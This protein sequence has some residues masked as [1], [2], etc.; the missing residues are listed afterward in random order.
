MSDKPRSD[1]KPNTAEFESLPYITTNGFREYDARWLFEKE[2]NLLGVQA[3]GLCLGTYF[4]QLGIKPRV[5]TGHD[6]RAYQLSIKQALM[7][8]LMNAGCEVI[9]IGLATTPMCY[10]AQFAL[11]CP[12]LAMVTAS[13]N[14]NG[15]TGVKMGANPPLTFGPDEMTALKSMVLGGAGVARPG[16]SYKAV[17]DFRAQYLDELTK[18]HKLS[19]SIRVAVACGNGTAGLFGPEA[20]RR[21]GADVVEVNCDLDY[22]FPNYNP[23][24]EDL[25]MLHAMAAALKANG[26]EIALGF[27]ADGDRCGVVD[28]KG[29]EIFADKVGVLLARDL[30]ALYPDAKFVVDVKSTGIF[31]I[32]PVLKKNGASVDY[33]KTGHSYIKSR[34]TE[35]GALAGF[36][37]SG[38]YFFRKPLGRG[39]DDGIVAGIKVLEMLDRA[40]VRKM[41]DLLG[42]LP[43]TWGSPT[44]A[45]FCPDDK[46]YA[47]VDAMTKEYEDAK[48]NGGKIL[49]QAIKDII[50]VNGVRVT[51][52][53]GTWGLVRASSNKPSLVVVVESPKS[54]GQMRAMF[55]DLDARLSKHPEVGEYDQKI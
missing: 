18:G 12:G 25:H 51:L 7:L 26:A 8:G 41:S 50:T 44:M 30:S 52:E 28:D 19:R 31:M 20:L 42:D 35:L 13:H 46:K 43:K 17:E 47:V 48:K 54:E 53:D 55:K 1:L 33:W 5:V 27:D 38:H 29:E 3:L 24:T 32:D 9:D 14:E 16:G 6:Y 39:Y 21:I 4:H 2:I 23:N 15:W 40:G 10:F 37:K 34:T 22:N 49:G 36:E 45:P 11:D